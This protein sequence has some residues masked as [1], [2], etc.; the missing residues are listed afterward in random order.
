MY[1]IIII[2]ICKNKF[3]E[4]NAPR[5]GFDNDNNTVSDRVGSAVGGN[6]HTQGCNGKD[7]LEIGGNEIKSPKR[8]RAVYAD[9]GDGDIKNEFPLLTLMTNM[10]TKRSDTMGPSYKALNSGH[11]TPSYEERI[12]DNE[13]TQA[14]SKGKS[15]NENKM[16]VDYSVEVCVDV[17]VSETSYVFG[18]NKSQINISSIP[19]VNLNKR[20]II[21]SYYYVKNQ[22]AK[23]HI[24]INRFN[25]GDTLSKFQDYNE[26]KNA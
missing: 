4:V 26:T 13:R 17:L 16:P 1:I 18:D 6:V 2:N 21:F 14:G 8:I 24:R 11:T 25:V 7:L 20:R 19:H 22:V 23:G 12:L 3:E 15:T 10:I 9:S 5:K